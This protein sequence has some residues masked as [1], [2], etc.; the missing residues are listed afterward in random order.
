MIKDIKFK[1]Q[2]LILEKDKKLV[3]LGKMLKNNNTIELKKL[4][5]YTSLKLIEKEISQLKINLSKTE[6]NENKLKELYKKIQNYKE[7]K[8]HVLKTYETKL[9]KII[10]II[11]NKYPN[12]LS[13]ILEH[14]M[15][16]TKSILAK[17]QYR[18][19]EII[20]FNEKVNFLK[21]FMI[22]IKLMVKA[23]INQINIKKIGKEFEKKILKEHLFSENL[24]KVVNEFIESKDLSRE[25]IE[26]YKL[27]NGIQE[28]IIKISS[29]IKNKKTKE[30]INNKNK[31]ENAINTVQTNKEAILKKIAE[32][33]VEMSKTEK[34]LNKSGAINSSLE[35]IKKLNQQ[36]SKLNEDLVKAIKMKEIKKVQARIQQLISNKESIESKLN[37]LNLKIETIKNEINELDNK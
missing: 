17:Y 34:G 4:K 24:E 6:D 36:I 30:N 2:K 19:T 14:K 26:E 11:I 23:I 3:E 10:E 1:I 12:N 35:T 16:I 15:N 7:N 25:I 20:K 9:K 33:F 37:T 27:M 32:E 31:I 29:K 5:S 13:S 21:K 22:N 28:E 8:K 18:K